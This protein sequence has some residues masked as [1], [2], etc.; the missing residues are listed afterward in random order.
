MN[1]MNMLNGGG[2]GRHGPEFTADSG[3]Q[4]ILSPL[5]LIKMLKHCRAGIPM[6]V[7]GMM[8][9]EIIDDYTISVVDVFAFP[10]SGTTVSVETIDENGSKKTT[11]L[12]QSRNTRRD[13]D[14]ETGHAAGPVR[15]GGRT[16]LIARDGEVSV[17]ASEAAE[18]Y[19]DPITQFTRFWFLCGSSALFIVDRIVSD[20]PVRTSWNW[21]LNNRD[22][23]LNLKLVHQCNDLGHGG[24]FLVASVK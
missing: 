11:I 1:F 20:R 22:E 16:L 14:P 23:Q 2:G 4:L 13:Y 9:G 7:M 3:E 17:V 15:R 24:I 21:L 10:Q 19:G 5:V 6:E 12:E 8:L 18:L